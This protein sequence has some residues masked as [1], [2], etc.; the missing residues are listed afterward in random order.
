MRR[1]L[2]AVAV[3]LVLASSAAAKEQNAA[4]VIGPSGV[5]LVEP[6]ATIAPVLKRLS[7]SEAPGGPFALVYLQRRMVPGAPGR[8]YPGAAVYCDAQNRCVHAEQLL[9]SFGSGRITGL[10][11]GAPTRLARLTRSGHTVSVTSSL[12]YAVELA[13]G[14]A[15]SSTR[16]AAPL[17]CVQLHARWRGSHASARPTAFCVGMNGGVYAQGRQYP[18]YSGLAAQLIH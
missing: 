15:A 1:L 12:A 14:Q 10:Y 4:I 5:G 16:R 11:R 3:A 2:I 18:L 9:G 13:F 6:Y 17:G 7:P 8:W